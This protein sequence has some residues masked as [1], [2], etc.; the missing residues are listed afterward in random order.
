MWQVTTGVYHGK[1]PVEVYH[2][3]LLWKVPTDVYCRRLPWKGPQK[4]TAGG[5]HFL[6]PMISF[7]FQTDTLSLV[8]QMYVHGPQDNCIHWVMRMLAYK[9]GCK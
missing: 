2:R 9:P 6:M 1:V 5:Y 3:R 7:V 8:G 4:A